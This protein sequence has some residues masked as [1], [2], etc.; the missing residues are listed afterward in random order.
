[1][2]SCS[3]LRPVL[4]LTR[5]YSYVSLCVAGWGLIASLQSVAGS[6][7]SMFVLRALLGI[8]EAA[9]GPGVPFYLSFFFKREELALRTGL[10]I[11]AA[12]LATSFASSLAWLVA[13]AGRN[14]PI[15]PWRMLFLVE[16]FPSMIVA[17]LAYY[18]IPDSPATAKWLSTRAKK[19]ATL[20]LRNE[21]MGDDE[22]RH[23]FRWKEVG[24]TL[25]DPKSYMTAVCQIC[26]SL[27]RKILIYCQQLMFFSCNVAFASL[28]PFLPTII[29]SSGT[30]QIWDGK[31]SLTKNSKSRTHG[32]SIPSFCTLTHAG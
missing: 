23:R 32:T 13:K 4:L 24:K 29:V 5:S 27:A 28:P 10:F 31:C 15:A 21:K 30:P 8:T 19:V 1:M 26:L 16:G 3:C 20:R 6:F 11:S 9:F 7:A 25:A 22:H 14:S 2:S 12:P 17:V 18:Q